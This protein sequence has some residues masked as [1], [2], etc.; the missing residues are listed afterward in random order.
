MLQEIELQRKQRADFGFETT[1]SGLS[2]LRLIRELKQ[3]D[4][5]IHLFFLWLASREL[6]LSRVKARVMRGGQGVAATV[7]KRRFGRSMRNFFSALS[8][9]RR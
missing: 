6:A 7:I 9:R 5:R 8:W 2:Y 4:Y 3:G 1:L